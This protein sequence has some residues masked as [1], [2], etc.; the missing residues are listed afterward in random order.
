[1][2]L[3]KVISNQYVRVV[4]LFL[5]WQSNCL[6]KTVEEGSH[7]VMIVIICLC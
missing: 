6:F 5:K 7:K 3:L 2:L 4:L 1:M